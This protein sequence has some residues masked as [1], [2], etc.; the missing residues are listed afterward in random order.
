[1]RWVVQVVPGASSDGELLDLS[2]GP[3]TIDVSGSRTVVVT[4]VPRV[5]T[6]DDVDD[7]TDARHAATLVIAPR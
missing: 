3:R 1:M 6:D 4:A 2:A 7:R 5:G